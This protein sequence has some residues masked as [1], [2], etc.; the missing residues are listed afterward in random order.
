MTKSLK[1]QVAKEKN[2]LLIR[3]YQEEMLPQLNKMVEEEIKG[4][5]PNG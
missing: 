3:Q 5:A 1:W 2:L 4:I